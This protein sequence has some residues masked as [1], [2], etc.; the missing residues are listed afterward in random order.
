MQRNGKG[1]LISIDL[2][3]VA[4]I[5]DS[6]TGML[7]TK[8]PHGMQPGWLIPDDLRER[9]TVYFGDSAEVLPQVLAVLDSIDIF[10]HDSL[11]TYEHMKMEMAL[12]TPKIRYGGLLLSDDVTW[13][14]AFYEQAHGRPYV[15]CDGFGGMQV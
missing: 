9:N 1:H 6:T 10:Q 4:A 13:N 8:L 15:I 11:H 2:P 14:R 5:P 7:H 12:A 3:A